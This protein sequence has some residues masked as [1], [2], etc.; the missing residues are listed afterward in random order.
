MPMRPM[1]LTLPVPAMPY[2]SVP[3]ISG[4]M[5]DLIRRRKTLDSAAIHAALP[6]FGKTAPNATPN[7]MA[8]KI[9]AVSDRRFTGL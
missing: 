8:M 7:S 9:H 6:T 2:T 1:V 4:A 3:K 5:M